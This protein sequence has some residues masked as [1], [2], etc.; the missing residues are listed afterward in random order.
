M[1]ARSHP[2]ILVTGAGGKL[3]RRVVELLLESG[4]A[5]DALVAA[6]RE[7]AR[8][9]DLSAQGVAVVRADFDDPATLAAAFAG[10]DRLLL[11]STD[12]LDTPGKRLRQHLA[13]VEAAKAAGIA[14]VVYTSM[15]RPEPG[16][17]IPFAPD[18]HGTEQAIAASG[19]GHTILRNSWYMENLL[20]SLPHVVATG[21]WHSAAGEG[22]LAHVARE[23]TARVAVAALRNTPGGTFDVTGPEALTTAEIAALAAEVTGRPISVVPVDD[24]TLAAG[25]KAAGLPDF[26]VPVLV[27]FDINTRQGRV[28]TVSDT[29]TRLTGQE[30][31]TLRAFLEAHRET[32]L[33]G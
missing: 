8:L 16:S 10:I 24:E 21:Q 12:A 13:A 4:H 15:P 25:L 27:G 14:H 19:L 9:A 17:P 23:D 5:P 2:R 7:P 30:P 1:S 29:V 28:E 20:L 22:R 32:L 6:T 26:F 18:H 31:Q 11:V 33:A 3:G